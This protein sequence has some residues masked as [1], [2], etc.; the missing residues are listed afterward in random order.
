MIKNYAF[1][2][3]VIEGANRI[4]ETMALLPLDKG[5]QKVFLIGD[6]N[7]PNG[8][9]FSPFSKQRK[10]NQSLMS[11]LISQ[12]QPHTYTSEKEQHF[13]DPS[14]LGCLSQF[15]YGEGLKNYYYETPLIKGFPWPSPIIRIAF[16][17]LSK[18]V[19]GYLNRSADICCKIVESV[20]R[21]GFITSQ[22]IGCR[23]ASPNA[24]AILQ[25]KIKNLYQVINVSIYRI[26]QIYRLMPRKAIGK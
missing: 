23:V 3:V 7:L 14:I 17:H 4:S 1:T 9:V 12:Q 6:P 15:F 25:I 16:I 11:R 13:F 26:I 5:F 22:E 20:L 21:S 18:T 24:Q 10:M 2:R 19:C 8:L